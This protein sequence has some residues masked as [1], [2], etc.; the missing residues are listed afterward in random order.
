[1]KIKKI[2]PLNRKKSPAAR[3]NLVQITSRFATKDQ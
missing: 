2:A 3:F 1:M